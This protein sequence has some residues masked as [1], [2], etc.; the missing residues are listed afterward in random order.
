MI[1]SRKDAIEQGLLKYFTGKPCSNGHI[2]ERY[3]K[4]RSCVK[5]SNNSKAAYYVKISRTKPKGR[6]K[7]YKDG[8]K[9]RGIDFNLTLPEFT[10]F[11]KQPCSYC[12]AKIDTI[13]L[14]RI[15]NSK[16]YSPENVCSCCWSCNN[17]KGNMNRD[18]FI[19]KIKVI[20]NNIKTER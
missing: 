5:C 10:K 14:D 9:Q 19:N 11:W 18:E 17:M 6:F 15:D 16:G 3:V 13:G 4:N 20:L 12:G 8:A 7:D 1:I 2:A